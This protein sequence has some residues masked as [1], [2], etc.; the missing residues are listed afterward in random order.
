MP[1]QAA[2]QAHMD[3]SARQESERVKA[4]LQ[5]IFLTYSGQATIGEGSDESSKFVAV[6]YNPMTPQEKQ[7]QIMGRVTGSNQ[8]MI[9]PRPPQVSPKEWEQACMRNKDQE[10]Y[11]PVPLV[12]AAALQGRLSWQQQRADTLVAHAKSLQQ[13]LE[14][15]RNKEINTRKRLLE[16]EL[17]YVTL[18]N[19]L[20]EVMRSV[21]VVRSMNKPLQ[22]DEYKAVQRL[23]ELLNYEG[24]MRQE[25]TVL[26]DQANRQRQ[27]LQNQYANALV[28]TEDSGVSMEQIG[29][30]MQMQHDEINNM[31]D[32]VKRDQ[33]DVNLVGNRI[34]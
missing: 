26:K 17:Q 1:A 28:T 33:Q 23:Q 16:K 2:L 24:H 3:A 20:M 4:K 19:R 31:T 5:K 15:L 13:T 11:V 18:R 8:I 21:E 27:A 7:M 30:A 22:S 14:F 29:I 12:G 10:N 32:E 25:L 34:V 6:T 9:P